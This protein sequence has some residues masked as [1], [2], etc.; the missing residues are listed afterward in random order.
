VNRH[1][2]ELIGANIALAWCT[3][4]RADL[5]GRQTLGQCKRASDLD[6]EC[7]PYDFVILL[8]K[9]FVTNPAVSEKQ[10][11][12]LLDHE[13]CHATVKLD[14]ET[15][16]PMVDE[17]NRTVYR[18]RKHDIEEFGE[19]VER[20]GCYKRD[21]EKFAQALRRAKQPELPLGE[22]APQTAPPSVH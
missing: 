19:V 11:E 22:D 15:H 20:H 17:R 18:V 21:L 6:R 13:L 1:H 10:R 12:A 5:D 3:S 14:P 2:R 9:D 16:E 8:N 7:A 4:W